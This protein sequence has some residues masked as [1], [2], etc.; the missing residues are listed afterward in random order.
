MFRQLWQL[1]GPSVLS[2]GHSALLGALVNLNGKDSNHIFLVVFV[3][4]VG[5]KCQKPRNPKK[6]LLLSHGTQEAVEHAASQSQGGCVWNLKGVS[7][8]LR[9]VLPLVGTQSAP[10][11][12]LLVSHCL[13][14]SRAV[15][16][17]GTEGSL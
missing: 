15:P 6:H 16:L 17:L 9:L 13:Q 2:L 11:D 10:L 14:N 3:R 1:A 7:A 8:V 4:I 12:C 5:S